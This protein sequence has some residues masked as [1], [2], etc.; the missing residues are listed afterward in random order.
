MHIPHAD[1]L[2]S[3]IAIRNLIKPSGTLVIST[4][5]HR[6][7]VD[8]ATSRDAGGRLFILRSADEVQRFF[9]RLDFRIENRFVSEDV[10]D[11][12]GMR[13]ATLVFSRTTIKA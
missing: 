4:S 9:E 13:W 2:D 5:T 1:F 12:P 6:D 3:A 8:P 10:L 11:R 7:D